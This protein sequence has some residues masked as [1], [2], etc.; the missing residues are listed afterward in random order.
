MTFLKTTVRYEK[1]IHIECPSC[2][3]DI[4][5]TITDSLNISN[6]PQVGEVLPCSACGILF[7]I[8]SEELY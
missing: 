3:F 2:K 6:I 7:K 5:I 1:K 4:Q 8:D